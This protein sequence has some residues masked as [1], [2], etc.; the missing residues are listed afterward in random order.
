MI[1]KIRSS[2]QHC[3]GFLGI[4]LVY[5]IPLTTLTC[6]ITFAANFWTIM[7]TSK[8]NWVQSALLFLH[9]Y[10]QRDT[11]DY[12]SIF[13]ATRTSITVSSSPPRCW[14]WLIKNKYIS[15]TFIGGYA[16]AVKTLM[17]LW[18]CQLVWALVM[19]NNIIKFH[20]VSQILLLTTVLSFLVFLKI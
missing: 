5:I 6:K 13:L 10:S 20:S 17:C 19:G 4:L 8:M 7:A 3:C 2:P 18:K 15:K 9:I 11:R 16:L 14:L 12:W 1:Y